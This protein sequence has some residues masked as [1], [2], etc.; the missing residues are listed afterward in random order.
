MLIGGWVNK[1][2]VVAILLKD[3]WA[4]YNEMRWGSQ[5]KS[6]NRHFTI[7]NRR[8]LDVRCFTQVNQLIANAGAHC[9]VNSGGH[10]MILRARASAFIVHAAEKCAPLRGETSDSHRHVQGACTVIGVKRSRES[11]MF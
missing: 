4:K 10:S 6:A 8:D 1:G 2:E 3:W 11:D 9:A 7:P 5:L